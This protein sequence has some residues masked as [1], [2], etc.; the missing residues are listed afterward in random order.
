MCQYQSS[1]NRFSFY[2]GANSFNNARWGFNNIQQ[3]VGTLSYKFSETVWMTHETW[4]MYQRGCP[5]QP[6]KTN[7][8]G[9]RA[10]DEP[11]SQNGGFGY[12]DGEIPVHPRYAPE[13]ATL[14][15]AMFRLGPSL[16]LTVRNEHFNDLDGERTA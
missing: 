9:V 4:Y 1:D 3:Y 13:Y 5:G 2:G 10:S 16:F 14:N 6:S 11:L 15:H 8:L 12:N 7:P